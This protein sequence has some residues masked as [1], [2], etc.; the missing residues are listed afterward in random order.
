[1]YI[2]NFNIISGDSRGKISVWSAEQGSLIKSFQTHAVDVLC[3][4]MDE[5]CDSFFNL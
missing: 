4:C 1:M 3:L 5:V 2:R